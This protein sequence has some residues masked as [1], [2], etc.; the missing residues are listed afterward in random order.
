[1]Y[2]CTLVNNIWEWL[3]W[4]KTLNQFYR[5]HIPVWRYTQTS[6][7]P[8]CPLTTPGT[9]CNLLV[10]RVMMETDTL[11]WPHCHVII[12]VL[13]VVAHALFT[14]FTTVGDVQ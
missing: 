2:S 4:T 13:P 3:F 10:T 9:S 11:S 1:M 7:G 14:R 6:Q 12:D 8:E 5:E